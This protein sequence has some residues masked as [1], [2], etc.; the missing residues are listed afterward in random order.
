[1]ETAPKPNRKE[2]NR[3]AGKIKKALLAAALAAAAVNEAGNHTLG[4]IYE[5]AHQAFE[6]N[7]NEIEKIRHT[8]GVIV[9]KIFHPRYNI[10]KDP[11]GNMFPMK[12]QDSWE[13]LVTLP[14]VP[15]VNHKDTEFSIEVT[16]TEFDNLPEA[17]N[18]ID[19]SYSKKRDGNSLNNNSGTY[20]GVSIIGLQTK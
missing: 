6:K 18:I 17:G 11:T 12:M 10:I 16:K 8:D 14:N 7:A 5:G 2:G 9:N 3:P 15:E 19:V 20:E 1:M 13:V 4:N